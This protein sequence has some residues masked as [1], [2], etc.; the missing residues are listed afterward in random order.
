MPEPSTFPSA[1]SKPRLLNQTDTT[2]TLAWRAPNK[3]GASAIVGYLLQYFSPQLGQAWCNVH[4]HV[5]QPRYVLRALQPAASYIFLV[6]AENQD[7][8]GEPSAM[9]SIVR[10]NGT[11]PFLAFGGVSCFLA[12]FKANSLC[13]VSFDAV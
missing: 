12:I 5:R 8:I 6:R 3:Q 7:G 1:P 13:F 9:S 11:G 4:D 10:M 2:V